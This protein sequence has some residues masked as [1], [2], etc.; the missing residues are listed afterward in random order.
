MLNF[1]LK[2][3]YQDPSGYSWDYY[4]D[5]QVDTS[6]PNIFYIIP[7]PQFVLQEGTDK[8]VFN[9]IKNVTDGGDNGSGTCQFSVELSVPAAVESAISSAI[10]NN[11]IQFP[12]VAAPVFVTLQWN[13]GGTVGFTLVTDG[14]GTYFS[15]PVTGFGGSVANFLLNLTSKQ[16][17]SITAVFSS[18]GGT[19]SLDITYNVSVPA[20]LRGVTAVLTFNSSVAYQY[21]VTQPTY[22]SWGDETSPGSAQGFL[23][24]SGASK[25]DLTWGIANP[26]Q[27]LVTSVTNWANSTIADLVNSEVKQEIALQ[28]L[29]SDE[30][31]DISTVSNFTATYEENMVVNWILSP[32]A[33]LPSFPGLGL[34]IDNFI[35][36][37]NQQQQVMVVSTNL[38]FTGTPP[39]LV[40]TESGGSVQ[41]IV[42]NVVVTV[43]YPGL[44]QE[45]GTFTFTTNSS[46][47]FTTGYD[48]KQGTS[49]SLTYTV[50]FQDK[51]LSPLT[52]T[53]TNITEANYILSITDAGVLSVNFDATDV[54]TIGKNIPEKIEI[55][56]SFV[57][58]NAA[59]TGSTPFDYKL[60]LTP[61]EQQGNITS[62]QV[63]P[64]NANYNY[65]VTYFYSTGVPF[66]APTMQNQ[67][68]FSQTIV[69]A[70]GEHQVNAIMIW[71]ASEAQGDQLLSGTISLWY[72]TPPNLP[73]WYD[74][75]SL[76]T[77]ANPTVFNVPIAQD[78][79]S[80]SIGSTVFYGLTTNNEPLYYTATL[81]P[82]IANQIVIESQMI[83]NTINTIKVSPT[84]RYFTLVVDPAALDWKSN[85]Y[86]QIQVQVTFAIGQGTAPS[87]VPADAQTQVLSLQ[88]NTGEIDLQYLTLAIQLG[89][90]VTY[91]CEVTYITTGKPIQKVYTNNLTD[92]TFNIP[93]TPNS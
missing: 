33:I 61:T 42:E 14:V 13:A 39:G 72:D 11:S 60:T 79:K 38:P 59:G 46:N 74:V 58:V 37:V 69:Q 47:T 83:Q 26:P 34:D 70:A 5:D 19:S 6:D 85:P 56:L 31:F 55:D 40:P 9:I 45:A 84:Q 52:A 90:E 80:N 67:T 53:I 27:Y 24:A 16:L 81:T 49:W 4:R 82:M 54:F 35:V 63:L 30:S 44:S 75:A 8:P 36:D 20:R 88:Y 7:Q 51:T 22:D 77:Q 2:G 71:L 87:Q 29:Q 41:P 17:E 76:P 62:L 15:A 3:T 1:A 68:G 12:G 21:Q 66:P 73:S 23:K 32:S 50:N 25:V 10:L 93:A 64:V 57:N 43:A 92:L 86:S 89:N 48:L 78:S 65:Q 18:P 28:G 91:D